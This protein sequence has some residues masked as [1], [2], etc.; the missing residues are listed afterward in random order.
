MLLLPAVL[1][2][3]PTGGERTSIV[4]APRVSVRNVKVDASGNIDANHPVLIFIS[5]PA[6]ENHQ[7]LKVLRQEPGRAAARRRP[8]RAAAE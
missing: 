3:R 5:F 8:V 1:R 4:F 2:R 7:K 6:Q